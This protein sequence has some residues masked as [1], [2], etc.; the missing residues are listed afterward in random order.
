MLII[1]LIAEMMK[2][3]LQHFP[4]SRRPETNSL[5]Q[6]LTHYK[7]HCFSKKRLKWTGSKQNLK[8]RDMSSNIGWRRVLNGRLRYRK[9]NKG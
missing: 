4:L 7:E 6:A 8:L 9:N 1:N 2:M 5:R 3:I